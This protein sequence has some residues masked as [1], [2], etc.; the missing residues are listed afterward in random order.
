MGNGNSI[1]LSVNAKT[2]I[3]ILLFLNIGFTI[4]MIGKYQTNKEAGYLREKTLEEQLQKRVNAAFGSAD[5]MRK[6]VEDTTKQREKSEK[7]VVE[8]ETEV[9]RLKSEVNKLKQAL[10]EKKK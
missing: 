2:I 8:L 9:Q 10:A 5:V 7:K 4:K 3:I 1:G 6:V